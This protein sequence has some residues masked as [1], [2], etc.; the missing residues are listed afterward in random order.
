MS[1]DSRK[2]I[3]IRV[4]DEFLRH[5]GEIQRSDTAPTTPTM[6]EVIRMAVKEMAISRRKPPRRKDG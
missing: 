5:V 2:Q 6:A 3:N 1:T 4:D